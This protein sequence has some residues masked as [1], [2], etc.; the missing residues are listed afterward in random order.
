MRKLLLTISLLIYPILFWSQEYIIGEEETITTCSGGFFDPG[1]PNGPTTFNEETVVTTICPDSDLNIQLE[2]TGFTTSVD[3]I[4]YVYD[5]QDTN[6]PLIGT[7]QGNYTNSFIV[8]VTEQNTTGCLTFEYVP[9]GTFSPLMGWDATISCVEPCQLITPEI[10]SISPSEFNNNVYTVNVFADL[11]FSANAVFENTDEGATYTWDFGDGETA[12]GLNTSHQYTDLGTYPVEFTVTDNNNCSYTINTTVDVVFYD[13]EG[14]C[15]IT[16]IN[17]DFEQPNVSSVATFLNDNNVPGWFTTATDSQMEFWISTNGAGGIPAYS[18]DQYIELNAN[19]ASGVYQ[20]YDTPIAGTQFF[21]SFAHA[22]RNQAPSGQDV[23]GVYAGSPGSNLTLVAQYSTAINAGWDV[24]VGTYIVPAN[25][26]TTRFEFRAIS[27]A[28]G[29]NTVG[30]FLDDINIIANLG[31]VSQPQTIACTTQ[32][33]LE[34]LGS[35]QWIADT[36]NPATVTIES[37][38]SNITDI[39]GLTELGTYNFTWTN[40]YC[41]ETVAIEVAEGSFTLNDDSIDILG[42]CDTD[43]IN[44]EDYDLTLTEPQFVDN[45][46]NFE[47]SYYESEEDAENEDDNITNP[48]NYTFLND[49]PYTIYVRIEDDTCYQITQINA[50][51]FTSPTVE[52][53]INLSTCFES[54]DAASYNLSQNTPLVIGNQDSNLFTVS[55]HATFENAENNVSPLDELNYEPVSEND[56]IYIRI[57]N[58]NNSDCYSIESFSIE[59]IIIDIATP[60]SIEECDEENDGET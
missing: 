19:Q 41:Q 9:D 39:T 58:N 22:A 20:D 57:E 27:T 40:Q 49:Q 11:T 6:A 56:T 21:Y 4:L 5:G 25:Q 30:N 43:G 7:Y 36:N 2:F 1:G 50:Q 35:G 51:I 34:A 14:D 31:I 55:Y 33:T 32:I 17:S 48:E 46:E 52:E 15:V 29:D 3:D 53:F 26:P 23:V 38:T 18:G 54:L 60:P 8:S 13:D 42:Q 44:S 47:I 28:S 10:T 24:K 16:T 12:T 59:T 37:P 45:P